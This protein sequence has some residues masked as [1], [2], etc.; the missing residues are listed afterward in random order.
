[1][2]TEQQSERP[3]IKDFFPTDTNIQAVNDAYY[4]NKELFNYC[5]A[6]DN[7]IDGIEEN[8][9]N[10][11]IEVINKDLIE[12][13]SCKGDGK[14]TCSNP[15]HG[16]ISA[17]S[18]QEVGRLGCPVCGHDPYHKI[19]NGENCDI[20]NGSG[21]INQKE[22]DCFCD[23]YNYDEEPVLKTPIQNLPVNEPIKDKELEKKLHDQIYEVIA[24][25]MGNIIIAPSVRKCVEIAKQYSASQVNNTVEDKWISVD[26][27][28]SIYKFGGYLILFNDNQGEVRQCVASF[29]GVPRHG[30]NNPPIDKRWFVY[31][32]IG[33]EIKP[34]HWQPLPKNPIK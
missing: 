7:Y 31:P 4:N 3:K 24:D 28:P 30:F 32:S 5:Q 23:E 9:I 25:N 27:P 21:R 16:F 22:F 15:D 11:P 29:E 33:H 19:K 13:P 18:S 14:E 26:T 2:N 8:S 1:M 20:C 10:E 6:L 17:L 34:T 12:C